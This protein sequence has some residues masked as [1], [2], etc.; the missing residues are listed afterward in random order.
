M[1]KTKRPAVN[2][3]P[4]LPVEEPKRSQIRLSKG[5][6]ITALLIFSWLL[7]WALYNAVQPLLN[8]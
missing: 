6:V 5:V 3:S 2:E 8:R 4:S 7:V 1:D